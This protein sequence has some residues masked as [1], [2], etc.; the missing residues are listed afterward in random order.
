MKKSVYTSSV[1]KVLLDSVMDLPLILN[2][3]GNYI[4]V[5]DVTFPSVE[6]K[7]MI[8]YNPEDIMR[9]HVDLQKLMKH[10]NESKLILNN[11]AYLMK[12]I[13]SISEMMD[14]AH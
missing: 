12:W 14:S 4:R 3:V 7:L 9:A 8:N 2:S 6:K 5:R 10:I 13:S 11:D 1:F